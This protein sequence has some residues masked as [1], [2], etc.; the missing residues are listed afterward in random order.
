LA[1]AVLNL[2]AGGH[3]VGYDE[4]ALIPAQIPT[5]FS[6]ERVRKYIAK[7][8]AIQGEGGDKQTYRVACWLAERIPDFDTAMREFKLWNSMFAQPPWDDKGLEHKLKSAY[9]RVKSLLV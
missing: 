7:I 6:V 5:N 2:H 3:E 9:A 1:T 4:L 8:E